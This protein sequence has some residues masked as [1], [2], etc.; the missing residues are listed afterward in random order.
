MES[1]PDA[2]SERAS[3]EAHLREVGAFLRARRAQL[4]PETVGLPRTGALRRVRGLR[5][6]EVAQLA[7]ISTDY[8]TRLEQ[9][10]IPP[11]GSVLETL[12]RVLRLDDDQRAY[13]YELAGRPMRPRASSSQQKVRPQMQRLLDQ[14]TGVP[15]MVQNRRFD[16]LAWNPMAA[17]LMVDFAKIPESERNFARLVFTHPA[18]RTLYADWEG[19]GRLCVA[20]LRMEAAEN[21][22]DAHLSALIAEL[23]ARSAEFREWWNAHLVASKGTG[24]E[25][26]H[27]P[28]VG[29]LNLQWDTL[30]STADRAQELIVWTADPASAAA[31]GLRRLKDE[32]ARAM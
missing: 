29:V 21:A 32:A 4:R 16:I 6:E 24:T 9:G 25:T 31:N 8:Y 18:M 19:V 14:L 13:L 23:S 10:R 20:L 27:H 12:A 28:R 30:V 5:R 17:A 15:A 3:E 22:N 7:A 11:S 2:V 26:F 1:A